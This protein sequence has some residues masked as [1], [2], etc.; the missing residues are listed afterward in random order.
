MEPELQGA[1]LKN[2]SYFQSVKIFEFLFVDT[3]ICIMH[4]CKILQHYT[5]TRGVEKKEKYAFFKRLYFC[6]WDGFLFFYS[7]QI[8]TFLDEI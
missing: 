6:Y 5:F 1:C 3:H 2:N 4:R 7:L 8:T